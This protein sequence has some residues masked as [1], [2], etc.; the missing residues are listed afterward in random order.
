MITLLKT[1]V[2]IRMDL[3]EL[4]VLHKALRYTQLAHLHEHGLT[5]GEIETFNAICVAVA[6][7]LERP[8]PNP[9][10]AGDTDR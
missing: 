3:Y 4:H 2:K 10:S 8:P 1:T 7:Y 6:G 5:L 9:P